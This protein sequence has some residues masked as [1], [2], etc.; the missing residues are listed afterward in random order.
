M[1]KTTL[2]I[3]KWPIFLKF[4]LCN[5]FLEN[6]MYAIVSFILKCQIEN[7]KLFSSVL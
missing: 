3:G 6:H 2:K 7:E 4:I 1:F 5:T